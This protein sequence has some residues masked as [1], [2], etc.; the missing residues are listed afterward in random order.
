[1]VIMLTVVRAVS[2][3]KLK[4][5]TV[6]LQPWLN[7]D[8]AYCFIFPHFSHVATLFAFSHAL[9]DASMPL[10]PF[11][12]LDTPL[13]FFLLLLTALCAVVGILCRPT[14]TRNFTYK[15]TSPPPYY[16]SYVSL[17]LRSACVLPLPLC[18]CMHLTSHNTS[19]STHTTLFTSPYARYAQLFCYFPLDQCTHIQEWL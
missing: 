17:W 11:A 18:K 10:R 15:P 16:L 8:N 2:G 5:I 4:P 3:R 9:P 19:P 7:Q 6:H 14:Q 12:L 13:H 1:M